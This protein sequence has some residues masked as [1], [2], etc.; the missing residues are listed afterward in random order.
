MHL[1]RLNEKGSSIFV[2]LMCSLL[3]KDLHSEL[4]LSSLQLVLCSVAAE[5][6]L[7]EHH[8]CADYIFWFFRIIGLILSQ[9]E[10]RVPLKPVLGGV[11][12][13]ELFT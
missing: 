5:K 9:F 6:R 4:I 2:S 10:N 8:H 7:P 13:V 1:D 11:S 3:P 12:T